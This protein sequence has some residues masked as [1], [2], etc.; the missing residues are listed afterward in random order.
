MNL[1]KYLKINKSKHDY[2]NPRLQMIIQGFIKASYF[3]LCLFLLFI[4]FNRA[5]TSFSDLTYQ[6]PRE[7]RDGA[8]ID[9]ADQFNKRVNPYNIE[10]SLP[11]TYVYGFVSPFIDSIIKRFV[12]FNLVQIHLFVSFTSVL[13]IC[14]LVGVEI[15]ISTRNINFT[16][17]SLALILNYNVVNLR[18]EPLAIAL[19]VLA[20]FVVSNSEVL[21]MAKIASLSLIAVVLFF[22]KP[23][24]VILFGVLMVYFIFNE[25]KKN[26]MYLVVYFTSLILI[27]ILFINAIF[28]LYFSNT[29]INNLNMFNTHKV[30]W[31]IKQSVDFSKFNW[32]IILSSVITIIFGF[33]GK[34]NFKFNFKESDK[35]LVSVV[36]NPLE[37]IYFIYAFISAFAL[38]MSLGQHTGTYMTYYNQL[39]VISL[40]VFS[41]TYGFRLLSEYTFK[42]LVYILFLFLFIFEYSNF[43]NVPK[44]DHNK[45]NQTWN[46]AID[47]I[48]KHDPQNAYLSPH[49]ATEAVLRGWPV[50]DNGQT[51]TFGASAIFDIKYDYLKPFFTNSKYVPSRLSQWNDNINYRL[52]NK[53]F[54]VVVLS[55]QYHGLINDLYLNEYYVLTKKIDLPINLGLVEFWEPKY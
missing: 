40:L 35:P 30:S 19:T 42:E 28:P 46:Q 11:H 51:D 7:Y 45:D 38:T 10:N 4:V 33:L 29:I 43:L 18:P 15:F 23:Y 53:Q 36:S 24:F 1:K 32:L 16:L 44:I 26:L 49:F 12:S 54:S 39:L 50:Y 52:S 17:V 48:D 47:Y 14:L 31:M 21:T 55:S 13:V 9:I 8:M 22:I 34:F 3:I 2:L 6:Y 5:V 27:S 25:S 20:L 41:I 37:N